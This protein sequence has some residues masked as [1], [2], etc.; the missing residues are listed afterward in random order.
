MKHYNCSVYERLKKK[1]ILK[2]SCFSEV[3]KMLQ[4]LDSLALCDLA[5]SFTPQLQRFTG[6]EDP[7]IHLSWMWI[8]TLIR[9]CTL[10]YYGQ[11]THRDE[12]EH[13]MFLL[14]FKGT[15]ADW[16][17]DRSE[18]YKFRYT[19]MTLIQSHYLPIKA[20]KIEDI[21]DGDNITYSIGRRKGLSLDFI[22]RTVDLVEDGDGG[23]VIVTLYRW[24]NSY[25]KDGVLVID[26][27]HNYD[28]AETDVDS[29]DENQA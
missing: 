19:V 9:A 24:N 13:A 10:F 12:L 17:A 26:D 8:L 18:I 16:S 6:N 28:E 3:F 1:R 21:R 2:V 29:D 14:G 7:I 23:D 20:I 4:Y 11:V 22:V 27:P 15:Q 5:P 25:I